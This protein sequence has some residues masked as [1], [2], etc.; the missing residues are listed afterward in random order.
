MSKSDNELYDN[1][2]LKGTTISAAARGYYKMVKSNAGNETYHWATQV[3]LWLVGSKLGRL[4]VTEL[5]KGLA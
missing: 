4:T 5:P 3:L 2:V 1:E